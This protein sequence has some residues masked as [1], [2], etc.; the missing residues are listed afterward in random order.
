MFD[1]ATNRRA[2]TACVLTRRIVGVMLGLTIGLALL[3]EAPSAEAKASGVTCVPRSSS[4]G[5]K[6]AVTKAGADLDKALADIRTAHY[7]KA[8]KHL[9]MMRRQTQVANTAAKALIGRPPSDPESDD[10]PGVAAVLRV[11][12][13]E[14]RLAMTLVPLFSDRHGRH[15]VRP[16]AHGLTQAVA[17]R[18]AM[19]NKVI[20]LNAGKRDDYVD[21]LSDTLP[22]YKTELSAISTELAGNGLTARGRT[23][24]TRAQNVV[25]TTNA[26]MQKVF[27]GGERSPRS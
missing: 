8:A 16:L 13:F 10:P 24:L 15:V 3:T 22:S 1:I 11:G 23:A 19:L 25:S 21:D 2:E 14:H 9:R 27:G 7:G 12:G 17:C 4:S 18:N 6:S 20:A 5:Y 26:A